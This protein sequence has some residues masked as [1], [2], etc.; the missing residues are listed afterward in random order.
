MVMS[1]G[2]ATD[3]ERT[4]GGGEMAQRDKAL[5]MEYKPEHFYPEKKEALVLNVICLF[6]DTS[7]R[8]H[9]F[10]LF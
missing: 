10:N 2:L 3:T 4:G 8:G 1:L 6:R 5:H 9:F 7:V